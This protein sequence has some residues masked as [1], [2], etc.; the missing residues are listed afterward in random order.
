M[1]TEKVTYDNVMIESSERVIEDKGNA[2]ASEHD[3]LVLILQEQLATQKAEQEL[4]R[5]DVKNLTESQHHVIQK[6]EEM[7]SKLDAILAFM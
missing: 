2:V 4:L 1:L 3:P 7:N 6:Q 5:E